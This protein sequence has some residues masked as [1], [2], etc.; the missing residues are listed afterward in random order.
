MRYN[1]SIRSGV[2]GAPPSI[3]WLWVVS[4]MNVNGTTHTIVPVGRGTTRISVASGLRV[5][6]LRSLAILGSSA[7]ESQLLPG[8]M[9]SISMFS[10]GCSPVPL[11]LLAGAGSPIESIMNVVGERLLKERLTLFYLIVYVLGKFIAIP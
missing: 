8:L 10:V 4:Y 2:D 7:S 11:L 6:L 1:G 9:P 3:I 5:V